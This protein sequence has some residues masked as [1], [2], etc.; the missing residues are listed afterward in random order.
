MDNKAL[1]KNFNRLSDRFFKFV[2]ANPDYKDLLISFLNDVLDN[3]PK[4]AERI[5]PIID[6]NYADREAVAYNQHE[7]LP[8]FDVIALT[9]D[10]RIFHVEVQVAQDKNLLPRMLYYVSKSYIKATSEGESYSDVQV[11]CI[12]LANFNI[13]NDSSNWY[14]LH[15][16][17]NV[18]NNSWHIRGMEFHFIE[19]PKL[20]AEFKRKEKSWPA[21]GL[22]R[23]LYYFGSIGGEQDMQA[24]AEQ[25]ARIKKF[26]ELEREFTKDPN[27]LSNYLDWKVEKKFYNAAL[28]DREEIGEKR[29][30]RRGEKRGEKRGLKQ[31]KAEGQLMTLAGLV[32]DGILSL[33]AAA[34]RANM[35]EQ[36][37]LASIAKLNLN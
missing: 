7:K 4:N 9:E 6:L 16:L 10:K 35:T 30:E 21:T 8:R 13:F 32:D 14:S 2:F 22:E 36:E 12:V 33:S 19:I 1:L 5:K 3:T 26:M 15:R 18:E 17:L 37:F 31:G 27:L 28:K 29:G 23:V 34:A 24:L 20:K 11:I 25:D